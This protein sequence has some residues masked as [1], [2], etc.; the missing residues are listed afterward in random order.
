[1]NCNIDDLK[2]ALLAWFAAGL[3]IGMLAGHQWRNRDART[4]RS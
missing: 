2:W 3:F 4:E 1:M